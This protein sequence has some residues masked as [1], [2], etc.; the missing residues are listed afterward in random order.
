MAFAFKNEYPDALKYPPKSLP[1]KNLTAAIGLSFVVL[2]LFSYGIQM[3]TL[4]RNLLHLISISKTHQ[5][6]LLLQQTIL[7]THSA[8]WQPVHFGI[9][10]LGIVL[11][12]LVVLLCPFFEELFFRGYMLN[13]L[14]QRFHPFTAICVSAFWFTFCHIFSK[15]LVQLPMIFLLGFCCGIIRLWSGRW[16]DAW[17]LHFFYNYCI[18]LPKIGFAVYRFLV[19]P[20]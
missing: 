5:Q 10:K 9:D 11:G 15:T 3:W 19:L 2:L 13:C 17:K 20:S 18:I 16:Q 7:K 4:Q 14:C 1:N 8:L 12:S 6:H